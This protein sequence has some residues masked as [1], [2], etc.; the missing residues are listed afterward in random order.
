MQ[1]GNGVPHWVSAASL[2]AWMCQHFASGTLGLSPSSGKEPAFP[3]L[4]AFSAPSS[5]AFFLEPGVQSLRKP[6][7]VSLLPPLSLLPSWPCCQRP[8]VLGRPAQGQEPLKSNW[9]SISHGF[10]GLLVGEEG[11]EGAFVESEASV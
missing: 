2:A 3:L 11:M 5:G 10:L 7:L 4:V 6:L 1:R 8:L 9:A